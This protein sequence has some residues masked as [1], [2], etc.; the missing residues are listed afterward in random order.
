MKKSLAD[1]AKTNTSA[2][3]VNTDTSKPNAPKTHSFGAFKEINGD[4][5]TIDLEVLRK[6]NVFIATPCY[7]GMLTDQYFLSMFRLSQTLMQHGINFR[8]TTLRNESLITRARNIMTAMF[9]E[10]ECTH[11]FFVDSDIEFQAQ[12][13]LRALAYD[14]DIMAAAY[15][16]K[17]LPIQYAINFKFIDQERRRIRVENGAVEVLDASTGFFMVKRRV[18]EKMMQEY[19]ELH[20]RNDSNIDPKF[21]Q[22]CYS[23]FDTIHDPEDNRYLSEDYTFCRRWQKL[24]GEIWL[25]PNTKLNHVGSYTFEG[26]VSKIIN[27]K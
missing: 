25:D 4:Q 26:D 16:K 3:D 5:A 19:P 10:S 23:F 6:Y 2:S 11:L 9:L 12:D 17:A 14:K 1:F 24:G 13:V 15:P 18:V 7:G 20:Y 21:N 22:Y 8:I 27:A